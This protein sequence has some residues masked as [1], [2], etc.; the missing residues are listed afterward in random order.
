VDLINE[1]IESL[2]KS[3]EIIAE[4]NVAKDFQNDL[5]SQTLIKKDKDIV[6]L[7]ARVLDLERRSM[8]KNLYIRNLP[9]R[10]RENARNVI[11]ELLHNKHVDE[12]AYDLDIVHRTG[13]FDAK[14]ARQRPMVVQVAKRGQVD[15]IMAATKGDGEYNKDDVRIT[16]QVPTEMRHA[17]AKLYHLAKIIKDNHPYANVTVKDQN[18]YIN[19]TKHSPPVV[20][21]TLKSLL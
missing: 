4:Q 11:K 8:N 21:P 5:L 1:D 16:R 12:Q 20:P 13:K 10:P 15:A 7:R 14:N 2:Q 3:I 19:N 18:L 6:T 17:T 9:E